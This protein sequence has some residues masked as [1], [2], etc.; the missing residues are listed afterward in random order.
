MFLSGLKVLM[1]LIRP[2]V[3]MD[4]R[5]STPTPVLSNFFAMYTTSR[6]LCSIRMAFASSSYSVPRSLMTL[7][8]FSISRG[9]GS[10]SAPPI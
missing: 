1:D 2:M 9:G 7:L 4:I 6:R 8:S 10:T 5:S 3:P